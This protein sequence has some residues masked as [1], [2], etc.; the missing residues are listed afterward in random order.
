MAQMVRLRPSTA[1][2]QEIL[3]IRTTCGALHSGYTPG[4]LP[5]PQLLLFSVKGSSLDPE[6]QEQSCEHVRAV[7]G[8]GFQTVSCP[9]H[10][11]AWGRGPPGQSPAHPHLRGLREQTPWTVLCP[12]HPPGLGEKTPG[13]FSCPHPLCLGEKTLGT[14][15]AP[16]PSLVAVK[17]GPR[18]G[19]PPAWSGGACHGTW[20]GSEEGYSGSL[21]APE[22][23]WSP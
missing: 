13:T 9:P 16:N 2:I 12:P 22:E 10:P 6:T 18:Q 3:R 21:Q 8:A 11:R 19:G 15:C 20:Q 5:D 17:A 4:Q 23:S 1:V 7:G 14:S